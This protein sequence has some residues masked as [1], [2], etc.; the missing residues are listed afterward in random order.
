MEGRGRTPFCARPWRAEQRVARLRGMWPG[1]VRRLFIAALS[2][3]LAVGFAGHGALA[4]QMGVKAAATMATNM[5]MSGKCDGCSDDQKAMSPA[6]CAAY[7]GS[8]IAM[9]VSPLVLAAVSIETFEPV[10]VTI[11]TAHADPPEPY[12]PRPAILN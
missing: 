6:I 9:P 10:A 1:L 8:F 3:A 12:P 7:C 11:G 5:P 2:M 4:T